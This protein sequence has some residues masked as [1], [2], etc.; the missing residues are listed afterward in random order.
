MV[1]KKPTATAT[2]GVTIATLDSFLTKATNAISMEIAVAE[3][4]LS[5]EAGACA[6]LEGSEV[7]ILV[8][9]SDFNSGIVGSGL[10]EAG[11]SL[12]EVP[13]PPADNATEKSTANPIPITTSLITKP[14]ILVPANGK[15]KKSPSKESAHPQTKKARKSKPS[16]QL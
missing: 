16:S 11:S 7:V 3:R 13:L 4:R 12:S 15:R 8:P 10:L 5:L 14:P 6:S 2:P 1:R 9:K